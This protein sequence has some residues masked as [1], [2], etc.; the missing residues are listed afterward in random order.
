MISSASQQEFETIAIK[1]A[2][3]YPRVELHPTDTRRFSIFY[4][5]KKRGILKG[6]SVQRCVELRAVNR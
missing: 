6:K 4:G 1:Y 5:D 2:I 3:E